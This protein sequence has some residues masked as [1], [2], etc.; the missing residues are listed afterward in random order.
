MVRE[1]AWYD[2]NFVNI[3]KL[4]LCPNKWSPVA[5]VPHALEN[6]AHSPILEGNAL[7]LSIKSIWSHESFKATLSLRSIHWYQ[8]GVKIPYYD[9][10]ADFSP[11]LSIKI[12]F[13]NLGAHILDV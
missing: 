5:K 8:W 10:I 2:F 4:V 9:C 6:N 1:D 11:F 12:C 3:L 13:T 7:K